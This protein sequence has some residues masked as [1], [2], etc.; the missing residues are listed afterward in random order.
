MP[1]LPISGLP[2]GTVATG[3]PIP[4]VQGGV[5]VKITATAAGAAMFEAANAAA[6][7]T[8]LGF[9]SGVGTVGAR[10]VGIAAA[11]SGALLYASAANTPAFLSPGANGTVLTIV[12]GAPAWAANAAIGGSIAV[13]Q[14]AYGSGANTIQG[15]AG[16]LFDGTTFTFPG[17][18]T[19]TNSA[20]MI[21]ANTADGAD[22]SDFAVAGGGANLSTRGGVVQVYGN[23]HATFPGRVRLTA[24][25]VVGNGTVT[26]G[27]AGVTQAVFNRDGQVTMGA[28][29]ALLPTYTFTGDVDTGMYAVAAN[30]IGLTTNAMLRW[31]VSTT[32]ITS[33][34]PQLGAAGTVTNPTYSFSGDPNTGM[35]SG[36]ADV[37][38]F[39]TGGGIMVSMS[40]TVM[41]V[42]GIVTT[43]TGS[44]TAP[45]YSFS[46]DSDV[47]MYR[48]SNNALGF[49]TAGTL[50][51]TLST[52]TLTSTVPIVTPVGSAG[53]PAYTFTG[54]TTTG[55]YRVAANDL[56]FATNGTQRLHMSISGVVAT[57]PFIA[58]DGTASAPSFSF[59]N[60]VGSGMYRVGADTIGF[61]TASTLKL[62]ISDTLATLSL[63]ILITPPAT[64]GTPARAFRVTAPAHTALTASTEYITNSWSGVGVT[65]QFATGALTIQRFSL[66]S[67]PTYG[68]VGSSTITNAATLAISAAPIA[69]TNAT[70]TNAYAL[71]I[72]DGITALDGPLKITPAVSTGT[73]QRALTIQA[74]AH[75]ALTASTEYNSMNYL[76]ATQ[77]FATGALTTNR[78]ALINAPTYAFVGASTLTNAATFAISG[79][80]IAGTNAT[81]TNAWAL[82]IQSGVSRFDG[83]VY[84]GGKLTVTGLIDPTGLALTPVAANPGGALAASTIWVNSADSNKLYFDS[85]AVSGGGGTI[86]GSLT[87]AGRVPYVSASNTLSSHAAFVF[88]ATTQQFAVSPVIAATSTTPVIAGDFE[89][90]RAVGASGNGP[91]Y[92]IFGQSSTTGSGFAGGTTTSYG[93]Q[94]RA[95]NTVTAVSAMVLYGVKGSAEN[96]STGTVATLY[97]MYAM[98]TNASTGTVTDLIGLYIDTSNSGGGTVT[99]R[100]GIY[101]NDASATNYF[102]GAITLD[103][104][105]AGYKT[106][107]VVEA[108]TTFTFSQATHG[109]RVVIT[110][111]GSAVTA[112]VPSTLPAGFNCTLVQGG[113]GQVTVVAGGGA[114]LNAYLSQVKT[115]A[116]YAYTVLAVPQTAGTAIFGG[117]TA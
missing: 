31:D 91:Q 4:T 42:G 48:P 36:G 1:D 14:I 16:F 92:G 68:F 69:G 52:A 40:T 81:L 53:A 33:T 7:Q 112:T 49:T 80:P 109:G 94:F 41:D 34:L 13:N 28:G 58:P 12:A 87:T 44:Q 77:Q 46:A 89:C 9:T 6:Q 84:I 78:F 23:E 117:T 96:N 30:N 72:Q 90:S 32:A 116:Q 15:S 107:V 97:G 105:L 95:V 45:A 73:P 106:G 59:T 20:G 8:L 108:G 51:L 113:A 79:A 85:A 17:A 26:I 86:G 71:W 101:Q 35:Y 24:G 99:N 64:T 55:M 5:T 61:T 62:S 100:Y 27:T 38:N 2:V 56:G 110:T 75:T 57:V 10:I 65:Q 83:D 60:N 21:A 19:F 43:L 54:D 25:D 111:N 11:V 88:D 3:G 102:A 37:L 93:G 82:W 104:I 76:A 70:F 18:A 66:I 39:A 29:T 22:T 98:A 74:A 50:R 67:A 47:G 114:T 115:A 103:G 63:P